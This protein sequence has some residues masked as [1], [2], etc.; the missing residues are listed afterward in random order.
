MSKIT[1]ASYKCVNKILL[2]PEVSLTISKFK[3]WIQAKYKQREDSQT[4]NK[5]CSNEESTRIKEVYLQCT[6]GQ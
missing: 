1:I 2:F 4:H 6:S 3:R 5:D